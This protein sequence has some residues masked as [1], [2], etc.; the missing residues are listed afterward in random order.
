MILEKV[1]IDLWEIHE[2][3]DC[4]NVQMILEKLQTDW[5][6]LIHEMHMVRAL[7]AKV[8]IVKWVE[9]EIDTII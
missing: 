8:P 3:H 7:R 5:W 1:Q 9:L 2:I 4:C 6:E